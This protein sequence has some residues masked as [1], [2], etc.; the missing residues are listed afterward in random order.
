M[1]EPLLLASER[2]LGVALL[3]AVLCAAVT[4]AMSLA[5]GE[6]AYAEWLGLVGAL[7]GLLGG[8]VAGLGAV[9]AEAL[10][11]RGGASARCAAGCRRWS[12]GC[13]RVPAWRWFCPVQRCRGP[14]LRSGS[15]SWLRQ[16]W[17]RV[18]PSVIKTLSGTEA[19][20][21]RP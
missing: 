1:P 9:A 10:L 4:V 18:R 8:V 19:F 5:A 15:S 2:V 16:P 6:V 12:V 17:P 21:R 13:A 11:T 20:C 14:S 7:I 3:T